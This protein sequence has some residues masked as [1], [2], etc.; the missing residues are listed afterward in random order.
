MERVT[1]SDTDLFAITR[2]MYGKI[3][4]LS[5]DWLYNPIKCVCE[6]AVL[7]TIDTYNESITAQNLINMA[8]YGLE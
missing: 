8:E 1:Y 6:K 2:A 5:I 4:D 7:F 3:T